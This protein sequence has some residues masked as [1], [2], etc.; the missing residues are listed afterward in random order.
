[1]CNKNTLVIVV[2]SEWMDTNSEHFKSSDNYSTWL[3]YFR[4]SMVSVEMRAVRFEYTQKN[5]TF[6]A[7]LQNSVPDF[8]IDV[9]SMKKLIGL[10][11]GQGHVYSVDSSTWDTFKNEVVAMKKF[12]DQCRAS[13]QTVNEGTPAI[14][15]QN[16][17]TVPLQTQHTSVSTYGDFSPTSSS[18][19]GTSVPDSDQDANTIFNYSMV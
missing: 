14:S 16:R 15:I 11:L 5:V 6:P 18:G 8:C 12:L 2:K 17:N 1:M 9:Q 7:C 10:I 19:V 13:I 3:D 4:T